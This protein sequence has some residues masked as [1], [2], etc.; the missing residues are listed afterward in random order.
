M[1]TG[2]CN[3]FLM[4]FYRYIGVLPAHTTCTPGADGDQGRVSDPITLELH[5]VVSHNSGDRIQT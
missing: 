2:N 5:M 3:S 1:D 4:L